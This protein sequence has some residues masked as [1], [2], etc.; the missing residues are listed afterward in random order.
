MI[1]INKI[2]L[3][4][5]SLLTLCP[6][7]AGVVLWDRLPERLP[8]HWGLNGEADGFS[9]KTFAV[10]AL[11]LIMLALLWV[12]VFFTTKDA[13]NKEQNPKVFGMVIW[14]VPIMS[15]FV[16]GMMYSHA[17]DNAVTIPNLTFVL[18]G[19]LFIVFGNYMPKC[20]PNRTIG[21]RIK[22][23]LE[24]EENWTRTHRFAG[25]VWFV[26]GMAAIPCALLPAQI[27]VYAFLPILCVVGFAPIVYSYMLH[28]KGI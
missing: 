24:S 17:L 15:M 28:K 9:G 19:V 26:G 13:K 23:T 2:K 11:P 6:I 12:C 18:F 14:I 8:T 16:S 3:I 21:V 22:W 4:I 10:I 7:I 20:K 27:A 25:I 1:K 5:A